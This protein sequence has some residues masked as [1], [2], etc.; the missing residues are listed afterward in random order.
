MEFISFR[1]I[2]QAL[3]LILMISLVGVIGFMLIEGYNFLDSFYM[4]VITMSTVGFGTIGEL[5]NSGK[6]FSVLLIILS[7]GTVVYAFTTITTFIIEGEMQLIL[8]KYQL[9]KKVDKLENHYIICGMGRNGREAA[10][11]LTRQKRDFVIIE[12]DEEVIEE[13]TET[14]KYLFIKGDA[15][16]EEILEQ[17]KIHDA[18]G[19]VSSL[20]TD[21]ENVYI[22]LTARG[23]NPRLKIVARASNETTINK[24]KRAGA[25]HVIVPNLIGGRRMA[26]VLTRP[27][28]MEFVDIVTGEGSSQLHLEEVDCDN[29]PKLVGQ[30][31]AGLNIRSKTGVLVLG[32]KNGEGELELN[33]AA[34]RKISE[35]DRLFILGT[36]DELKIFKDTYLS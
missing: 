8:T 16:H 31:L 6:A 36:D 9:S 15:T 1:R 26:N 35:G 13:Y 21:A 29:H 17:A 12:R 22:T 4:T 5:S 18:E 7:S 25:D 33:L 34:N 14:H 27:A 32:A 23:M 20:S 2:F 3:F 19:L 10:T 30:T 11:E 24:L 28:L